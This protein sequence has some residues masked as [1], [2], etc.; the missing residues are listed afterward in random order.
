LCG[1]SFVDLPGLA[2]L[3]ADP[4]DSR[5]AGCRRGEDLMDSEDTLIQLRDSWVQGK[6][7]T[8]RHATFLD[9]APSSGVFLP[10][11]N[12]SR[13]GNPDSTPEAALRRS[14]VGSPTRRTK[15]ARRGRSEDSR[16]LHDRD[17]KFYPTFDQIIESGN[18]KPIQPARSPFGKGQENAGEPGEFPPQVGLPV[19]GSST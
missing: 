6:L 11:R 3:R 2:Q 8:G 5:I 1:W 17:G 9:G 13:V 12:T 14:H 15:A 4:P 7:R 16:L 10:R 18:V 19:S